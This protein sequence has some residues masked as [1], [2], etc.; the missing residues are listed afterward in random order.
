VADHEG[1]VLTT[2]GGRAAFEAKRLGEDGFQ[3][4]PKSM[5]SGAESAPTRL[6]IVWISSTGSNLHHHRLHQ[7]YDARI[8]CPGV[9]PALGMERILQKPSGFP[10]GE[11]TAEELESVL[12]LPEG[13]RRLR[14]HF[15]GIEAVN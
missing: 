9:N 10:E 2:I 15:A 3:F 6:K 11:V 12:S 14:F 4:I 5:A 1:K 7:A 8:L 13:E